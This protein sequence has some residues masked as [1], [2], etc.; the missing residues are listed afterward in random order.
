VFKLGVAGRAR[1]RTTAEAGLI[2]ICSFNLAL[3]GEWPMVR[4]LMPPVDFLQ[5][6]RHA[7]Q[8]VHAARPGGYLRQGNGGQD[9]EF[10]RSQ[11]TLRAT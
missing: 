10:H 1:S 9:P 5:T 4:A 6:L 2:M 11:S 3:S 7:A 8:R